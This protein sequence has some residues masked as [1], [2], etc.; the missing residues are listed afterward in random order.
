[1]KRICAWCN[2]VIDEG[3]GRDPRVKHSI[4]DD[5]LPGWKAE[6]RAVL[7]KYNPVRNPLPVRL[8]VNQ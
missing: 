7:A 8:A 4:C 2:A 5:C 6:G 3:D 1:M